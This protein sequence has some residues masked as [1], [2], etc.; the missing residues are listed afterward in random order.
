MCLA[1]AAGSEGVIGSIGLVGT[2]PER[3][4]AYVSDSKG[5]RLKWGRQKQSGAGMAGPGLISGT[6]S[7]GQRKN[8]QP[9]TIELTVVWRCV[10]SSR[11]A[12][13]MCTI[14]KMITIHM[15]TLCQV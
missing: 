2:H 1:A 7:A 9:L 15:A 5:T 11:I 12:M 3:L 8:L 13:Y 14:E 10:M 6:T 4:W